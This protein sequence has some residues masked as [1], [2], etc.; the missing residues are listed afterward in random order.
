MA[1]NSDFGNFDELNGLFQ[2]TKREK[3]ELIKEVKQEEPILQTIK[4]NPKFNLLDDDIVS[5]KANYH[6]RSAKTTQTGRLSVYMTQEENNLLQ[7]LADSYNITKATLIRTLI[8][9][10]RKKGE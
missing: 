5:P 2:T 6:G 1:K 4:R 9:N 7:E 3:K 10:T 8:L